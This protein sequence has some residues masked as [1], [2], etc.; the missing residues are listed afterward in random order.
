VTRWAAGRQ[1]QVRVTSFSSAERLLFHYDDG[2][3]ADIVLLDIEMGRMDGVELARRLRQRNETMQLVFVTGYTDY[4]AQGYDVAA[5]H[6]LVKPVGEEKLFAVLDRAVARLRKNE[7]VLTLETGDG[8]VRLPLRRIRYV[9]VQRNYVTVHADKDYTVKR[10]LGDLAACLD[11][12][13]YRVGRSA[14]VNLTCI[15]R[16]TKTEIILDDGTAVPLPRGA[17]E[18]VNRAIIRQG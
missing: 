14:V 1:F 9:D 13:F 6:Y 16:V 17:Y 11:D 7:A 15:Q 2:R 4:I 3:D 5:L 10:S 18:G 8:L 12:R